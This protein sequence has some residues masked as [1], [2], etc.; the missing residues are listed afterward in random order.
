MAIIPQVITED[1]ASGAQVIDGSLKFDSTAGDHLLRTPSTSGNRRVWTWSGWVKRQD[2]DS[3][4]RLFEA[5]SS[6]SNFTTITWQ[7]DN[8]SIELMSRTGGTNK[9]RVK[10]ARLFRDLSA[11]YHVVV[12]MNILNETQTEKCKI[13]INGERITDF[14]D[15]TQQSEDE[16]VS[17]V[18]G[19]DNHFIGSANN[20]TSFYNGHMSQVYLIDGIELD[21]SYF[22]FTDPLTGTWRPKKYTGDFNYV[23]P[24]G[25]IDYES[26][27]NGQSMQYVDTTWL[28][29]SGNTA[30]NGFSQAKS[31]TLTYT[32]PGSGIAYTST[33]RLFVKTG[34]G[35][36][37][38]ITIDGNSFTPDTGSG[39]NTG[40]WNDIS[41]YVTGNLLNTIVTSRGSGG[42]NSYWSAI[43]VDGVIL[44]H[45]QPGYNGFYLP[46][47]GNSPIGEDKSGN[48]NNYRPVNFGGSNT[49]EKATGALPILNTVNGGR[50][51]TAG[52]RTDANASNLILAV[53]LNGNTQDYSGQINNSRTPLTFSVNGNAAPTTAQSNFY[54]GS[55]TFDGTTDSVYSTVPNS[56]ALFLQNS[57]STVECWV[58]IA[59][60]Q[61]D[62]RYFITVAS[63]SSTNA[64]GS[65]YLRIFQSKFEFVI[66]NGNT[67]YKTTGVSN[68][69]PD[70]WTHIAFVREGNEQ[71]LYQD[72]VLV[73]T[74]SHTVLP[75]L[76][77]SSTLFIGSSYGYSNTINAQ[78]Q[79][80]R[81]YDN[82]AKYTSN[83]IPASTDPDILPD[84]PSGVAYG[85]ALTKIT[86][87]AVAF[88]GS[89]DFLALNDSSDF[90][91]NGDFTVEAFVY[92][93]VQGDHKNIFSTEDFDFKIRGNGKVRIYTASSGTDTTQTVPLNKWTHL[94]LVRE[95]GT[96]KV[97]FDGVGETVSQTIASDGS[98]AAEIGRRI[99]GSQ[100][101]FNGFISN[102]RVIKGTALYTSNFTPPTEPLTAVTNTKLLC[103]QS[104][105]NSGISDA[106]VLPSY[107][108]T[109]TS[110]NSGKGSINTFAEITTSPT[111]NYYYDEPNSGRA[112]IQLDFASTQS[113]VTSIKLS[114]G[115]YLNGSTYDLYVNG[116]LVEND[117]NTQ[118][119][120]A[121]DTITISSTNIDSI[122]IDGSDGYA[123]GAVKFNDTLVSGTIGGITANGDAVATNFN[124]F[125]DD[126]NT[127]RGQET[128]YAT[129]NSN[130][131]TSCTLSE[132][133]LKFITAGNNSVIWAT[134]SIPTSGKWYFES[135]FGGGDMAFM[136]DQKASK[137]PANVNL[138][139]TGIGMFMY[140]ATGNASNRFQTNN[141]STSFNTTFTE[142]TVGDVYMFEVDMDN[143]TIRV[144]KQD[145]SD[146]GLFTMPAALRS[147][148]LF[149]GFSVTTTWPVVTQTLNFGQKP[150]KFPP[151]D[152]FQPLCS[153]NLPRPTEAAVRPDKY[154]KTML[155]TGNSSTQAITGVGFQPDFV[156][157]KARSV[158]YAHKL[159]DAVR[160]T[161]RA[162]VTS[163]TDAEITV[164]GLTSFDS[165]GFTLGSNLDTNLTTH[166]YVGWCWKGGTPEN[167]I[168]PSASVSFDG[169]SGTSMNIAN[170]SDFSFGSGDWTVECYHYS[171]KAAAS[172]T[173]SLI[174]MWNSGS[175]RRTWL[176]NLYQDYFRGY[177]SIDGAAGGS[178]YQVGDSAVKVAPNRWYHVALVR[179]GNNLLLFQDGEL[180]DTTDVTGQSVYDNT[181]DDLYIGSGHAGTVNN[182]NGYISNLRVVK[183]TTLYTANFTPP[184]APLTNVTNTKLLC[185]QST[186]SASAATVAPGS[187][188]VNGDAVATTYNPFDA[189]RIDGRVYATAAEAGLNGGTI[190]PT[191][192][193]V[194]TESG[195]SIIT[196]TG[197][198]N[199]SS[200]VTINHGLGDTPAFIIT[201]K[202][203]SGTTDNGW[204]C[205]HKDLGGNYGIWLNSGN[206]RNPS[207]WGG[208][209]N[210]S[211]TVFSPPDLNYGNEDGQTYVNYLW[212]EVP[213]FSKFGTYT[214]NGAVDGPLIE[215]G[216]R[217]AWVMVKV[218]GGSTGNS[219]TVWDNK[220]DTHNEMD[221]YL[222]PNETQQDGSYSAIKMDFYSNGFKPRGDIIH[223][224]SNGTM[225]IFVAF[226]EVPTFNLYGGQAN[227]R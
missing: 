116:V 62:D 63:G 146:S 84:T 58:R 160:G 148:P 72:G 161:T 3:F 51:A 117:R 64:E 67:Q 167:Y 130:N 188:T 127:V 115:G 128:G 195:F 106:T 40:A 201:K 181:T 171:F 154:F 209:T 94:A 123:I 50:V 120:W 98:S 176:I 56:D 213:G 29:F 88:D 139:T 36:A 34:S 149:P 194:N 165:D 121:E 26:G 23:S 182:T 17:F 105:N 180:I 4:R 81:I 204:S 191:G 225:Y 47:D 18:N 10:T 163:S 122:R 92:Q 101:P 174:G 59:S 138:T 11:W 69:V 43:E 119:L 200:G 70:K 162:L 210:I 223:Q 25:Q 45:F 202:R 73:V 53:P 136:L 44:T 2:L 7:G 190:T 46:F 135:T 93:T 172:G 224:N 33:I 212:S 184:T 108:I 77:N 35:G 90:S 20:E 137:T 41:S 151:P 129:L 8:N 24:V 14:D 89:L 118:T 170:S 87:G 197:D 83:F 42:R 38:N 1:R 155:W 57:N 143:G 6:T 22:G 192:A 215:C 19:T 132:G 86:D 28:P 221:L 112:W 218:A 96:I 159:F 186:T 100:E 97:Y 54:G 78:I 125:N 134:Q 166:T 183:G 227:A 107:D 65:W 15:N 175:N 111:S 187:I 158:G 76:N 177:F 31:T 37:N 145:G 226:A 27:F 203:S 9:F 74:T 109:V 110:S 179:N 206:T 205:W 85:S 156:W 168:S 55:Y 189:Y 99:R 95:S 114:G 147:A 66:V 133:N 104:I 131:N 68:Y 198:G 199:T 142:D 49:I 113:S 219:W 214:G 30:N 12:S 91:F 140:Y 153:A 152:G 39:N 185:C 79:D 144:R 164:S 75:N 124:P 217:P 60:G 48:G 207:M 102:L 211:S 71:R 141:I 169:T 222:H 126:I 80:A 103:C 196:Y 5:G 16:T 220:R 32:A 173:N 193:S 216:F 21:P 82:V 157:G 13:Y 61:T 178:I 208:H 52:V 150:F